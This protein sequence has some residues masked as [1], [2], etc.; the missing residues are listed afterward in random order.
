MKTI[1]RYILATTALLAFLPIQ[2]A[3]RP[4][5]IFVFTDD[6]AAHAISAYGSKINTTPHMDR[7]AR[8]GM[9]FKK[10]YVC[11]SICGPSRAVI[12]TGKYNHLNGYFRNG[13]TFD[14]SQMTFPKLLRKAGYTTAMIGKWHLKARRRALITSTY[15]SAKG[16]ITTRA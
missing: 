8:E 13:L 10:C 15:S 6:H 16:P 5:I 14:G 2:A 1:T 3:P 7:I 9:L 12:L 4:N 11:N